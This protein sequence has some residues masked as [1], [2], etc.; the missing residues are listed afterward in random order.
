MGLALQDYMWCL[1]DVRSLHVGASV[2]LW[3]VLKRCPSGL[4]AVGVTF[5]NTIWVVPLFEGVSIQQ[6]GA[7]LARQG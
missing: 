7:L 3:Y 6:F 5:D 1:L 2:G 4:A